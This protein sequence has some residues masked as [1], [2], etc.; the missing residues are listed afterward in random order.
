MVP[1]AWVAGVRT[2]G[3]TSSAA[4]MMTIDSARNFRSAL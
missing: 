4:V 1:S 3:I 2:A